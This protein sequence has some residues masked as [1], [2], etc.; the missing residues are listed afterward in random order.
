MPQIDLTDTEYL[1]PP[2]ARRLERPMTGPEIM[3]A[4]YDDLVRR[5]VALET[6]MNRLRDELEYERRNGAP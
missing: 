6:A 5:V 2:S 1:W 3:E 4:K